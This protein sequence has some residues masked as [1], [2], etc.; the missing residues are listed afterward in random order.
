MMRNLMTAVL[1]IF[2][3]TGLFAE[4]FIS[5]INSLPGEN[6]MVPIPPKPGAIPL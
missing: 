4:K 3:S 1:M 5:E 2:Y 6:G